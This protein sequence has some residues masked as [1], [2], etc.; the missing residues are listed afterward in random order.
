MENTTHSFFK[1]YFSFGGYDGPESTKFAVQSATE[2]SLTADSIHSMSITP[3]NK[4]KS[5]Y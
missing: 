2:D 3:R 4:D 5:N 1:E